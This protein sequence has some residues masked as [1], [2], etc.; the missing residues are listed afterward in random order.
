ML[1]FKFYHHWLRLLGLMEEEIQYLEPTCC[2]FL[3]W[4]SGIKV[5][6]EKLR[7]YWNKHDFWAKAKIHSLVAMQ[8]QENMH[9]KIRK[10]QW[11]PS[12]LQI[13]ILYP[14][15]AFFNSCMYFSLALPGETCTYRLTPEYCIFSALTPECYTF[16]INKSFAWLD[17]R[18]IWS[19]T[20]FPQWCW[21]P[22]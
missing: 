9:F 7:I 2:I 11:C 15:D 3:Y 14:V 5:D 21:I 12:R 18:S 20:E 16:L 17:Q 19:N 10:C 1:N 4:K 22:K 6:L 13:S 8:N